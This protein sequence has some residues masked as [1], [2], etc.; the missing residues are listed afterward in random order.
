[1]PS[2]RRRFLQQ[3]TGLAAGF[4]AVSAGLAFSTKSHSEKEFP[5]TDNTSAIAGNAAPPLFFTI[6]LA[7]WSLH[8]KL[9]AK[10]MDNLDFPVVAKNTYGINV[11]EY[12]N[13]FFKDKANDTKYLAEL[14]KRC[15]DN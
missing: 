5:Q 12:V 1:M 14:L 6:S 11:V 8:R 9:R 2:N 13:Q 10:E 3:L 7:Q 4:G 15:N